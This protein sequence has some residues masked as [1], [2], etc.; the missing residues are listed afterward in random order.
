MLA[1]R[2]PFLQESAPPLCVGGAKS[3]NF[4][5]RDEEGI[6]EDTT[7]NKPNECKGNT[8]FRLS[9]HWRCRR[10]VSELL[11]EGR[12]SP[13]IER[14]YPLSEVPD[15]VRH[16]EAGKVRRKVAITVTSAH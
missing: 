13:S 15:A 9:G 2:R 11:A 8:L 5:S 14:T 7:H 16:L 4:P 6:D 1:R 12:V 3:R 10:V